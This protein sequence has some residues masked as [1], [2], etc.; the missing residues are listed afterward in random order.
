MTAPWLLPTDEPDRTARRPS[1]PGGR[2]RRWAAT[3]AWSTV[4]PAL[5]VTARPASEPESGSILQ[6]L[7]IDAPTWRETSRGFRCEAARRSRLGHCRRKARAG[8]CPRKRTAAAGTA[9]CSAASLAR[10][11]PRPDRSPGRSV[12][13]SA[14]PSSPLG[15]TPRPRMAA[16]LGLSLVSRPVS[17]HSRRG[18]RSPPCSER[19]G[20]APWARELER[21]AFLSIRQPDAT[22]RCDPNGLPH[23]PALCAW[24]FLFSL[25][26]SFFVP[27]LFFFT[28][29]D[30]RCSCALKRTEAWG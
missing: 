30:N 27:G 26:F 5:P 22:R 15:D 21:V 1:G 12:S 23:P 2:S 11:N 7:R 8:G 10:P 29:V 18:G 4:P 20:P 19:C 6:R 16:T 9:T 3:C 28:N 17:A 14:P 24:P 13:P 25:A